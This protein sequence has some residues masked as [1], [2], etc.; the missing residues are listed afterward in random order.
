M[1]LSPE[2]VARIGRGAP[3]KYAT[4]LSKAEVFFERQEGDGCWEWRGPRTNGQP[5][6][7]W[8]DGAKV[9][10]FKPARV[11]WESVNGPLGRASAVLHSCGNTGCVNPRHLSEGTLRDV[12]VARRK[13]GKTVGRKRMPLADR[14]WSKVQKTEDGCWIWTRKLSLEG[15]GI[16]NINGCAR[17]AHRVAFEL[18]KGLIPRGMMVCHTCDVKSCVNP[19]HLYAGT[20]ADNGRDYAARGKKTSPKRELVLS[21]QQV[22]DIR[23]MAT[24]M[25]VSQRKLA[26]FYGVTSPYISRIVKGAS[27]REK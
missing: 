1:S 21:D 18:S 4:A 8:W 25:G 13:A 15:Y 27:R 26:G 17:K 14:F 10:N 19:E 24:R 7:C 5:R 2:F 6:F 16:F 23:F 3:R 9:R 12:H 11:L 22:R 20:A